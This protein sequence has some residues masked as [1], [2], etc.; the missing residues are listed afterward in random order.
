[1]SPVAGTAIGNA[2]ALGGG[3]QDGE[4]GEG[5]ISFTEVVAVGARV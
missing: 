1:M 2:N 3:T 4:L 5:S